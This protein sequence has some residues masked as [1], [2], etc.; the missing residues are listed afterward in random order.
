M[1]V[2]GLCDDTHFI[3]RLIVVASLCN[4]LKC[5]KYSQV[6]ITLYKKLGFMWD[7]CQIQVTLLSVKCTYNGNVSLEMTHA[8]HST[9][10]SSHT[11]NMLHI[12]SLKVTKVL[13]GLFF[14][15]V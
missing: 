1:F 9:T 3:H 4:M 15:S 5:E 14:L 6:K 7:T 10:Y 11:H 13:S 2:W 8:I 12:K